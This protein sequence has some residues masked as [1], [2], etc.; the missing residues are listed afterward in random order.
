MLLKSPLDKIHKDLGAKFT[1]FCGFQMPLYYSSI[2]DEHL[3]VRRSVGLFDVSHMSNVIITGDQAQKL[4][5]LSTIE[6]ATKINEGMSQYTA[7]L[8]E[9]GS[10][11]DD[12]IF[13]NLG[14]E[15]MII[16]NAG[17]SEY[18]TNWLNKKAEDFDICAKAEDV[19]D[20]YVILAVQG[21]NS[22]D[23]LQKL[24][25]L[26]LKKVGFFK[27][28]NISLSGVD[29]VISHTGYTGELGYE[30]HITPTEKAEILF[31]NIIKAG[32]EFNIKPI[33]L[34]ARDTLRLEKGFLLASN[35][36]YTERT[37]LEA[38]L[39][40]AIN[41]EHDFIGKE[42]LIKQKEKGDYF[43]LT[44]LVCLDKGIPR[45]GS[46]VFKDDKKVGIVSSGTISPCL[47]TGIALAYIHPD[48]REVDSILNIQIRGK[49]VNARIVKPPIVKKDWVD[50]H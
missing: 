35:E 29:C 20:K 3:T 30:I 38:M 11:I 50:T 34:G 19:S 7:I 8:K 23:T 13:M 10:I 45:N 36:F 5:S 33:G 37:P 25:E 28:R 24:T 1:E 41:W 21:P 44:N 16:P 14:E 4:I 48:Y 22:R 42:A 26:D 12:T 46:E 9:N 43:R 15:Y 6:D 49:T 39:S 31:D 17:M 27:C 18:V 32:K 2:K 47:N 40:W